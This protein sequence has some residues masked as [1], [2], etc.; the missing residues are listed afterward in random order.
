MTKINK[1]TIHGFKSFAHKTEIP[2]EESYN[3][4][5][6][7][8]GSGKSNIGDALCF[9]LGRLSAKSMRAEK[10]ANLIFNGGKNKSPSK[11]GSV[12]IT[13]CNETKT[14]PYD[15]K[16]VAVSRV[17][18]PKGSSSYRINGKKKTRTEVLDT[19][20]LAKINPEGYNIILQGDITRFVT[21]SPTERRKII[22]EISDVSTYD[23]KKN[24][25]LNELN[26]VDEKL[27]N[28][29]IILKDIIG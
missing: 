14:F 19:L 10:A 13:F 9:V 24:K 28:A 27:T 3:C 26:R 7:P 6:G 11:Q 1:V 16:E 2:F 17:I 15:T 23:E 25:A 18:S 12:E 4:V 20:G 8:N 21:M 5:L 29:K 22:E